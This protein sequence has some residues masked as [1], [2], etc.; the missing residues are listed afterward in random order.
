MKTSRQAQAPIALPAAE[1]HALLCGQEAGSAPIVGQ[2]L[3]AKRRITSCFGY[4]TQVYIDWVL[5]ARV[6]WKGEYCRGML[7][8]NFYKQW[9]NY[10][11]E[12]TGLE[13]TANLVEC[14]WNLMAHGDAREGKWR[15]NWRIEYSRTTSERGVSSITNVDAHTSAGSSRIN[16][17]S[18]RFK[19]TP[20]YRWKTKSGF[21][22][23]AFIFQ[24]QS[25]RF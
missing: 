19:W 4:R 21:C 1:M 8:L 15:V 10:N 7:L 17:R 16:W 20:P 18:R 12:G 22:A 13:R 9:W 5:S 24:T 14:I 25:V 3:Q 23:C 6:A 2:N 11:C